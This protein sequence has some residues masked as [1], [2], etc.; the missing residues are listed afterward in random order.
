MTGDVSVEPTVCSWCVACEEYNDCSSIRVWAATERSP[1]PVYIS[2]GVGG[3][4][5]SDCADVGGNGFSVASCVSG[6]FKYV[7][8]AAAPAVLR[9]AGTAVDVSCVAVG[10]SYYGDVTPSARA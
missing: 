7:S 9:L 3:V 2:A 5:R 6:E 1:G 4:G 8:I 10:K